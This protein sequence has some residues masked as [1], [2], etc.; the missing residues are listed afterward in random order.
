MNLNLNR[1][2]APDNPL[3]A[4]PEVV[5]AAGGPLPKMAFGGPGTGAKAPISNLKSQISNANAGGPPQPPAQ[6]SRPLLAG[7]AIPTQ[8]EAEAAATVLDCQRLLAQLVTQID[9]GRAWLAAGHARLAATPEGP[10]AAQRAGYHPELVERF[11]A[12]LDADIQVLTGE[13][14][15]THPEEALG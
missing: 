5:A 2:E 10:A 3:N 12:M 14:V 7:L 9:Q 4:N 8:A 15:D 1:G 13:A 11:S 6:A